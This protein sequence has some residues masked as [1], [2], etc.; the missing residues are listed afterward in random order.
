MRGCGKTQEQTFLPVMMM[1]RY[2]CDTR[3][4]LLLVL[5]PFFNYYDCYYILL[6]PMPTRIYLLTKKSYQPICE[7]LQFS[8]TERLSS[9]TPIFL[10]FSLS[11]TLSFPPFPSDLLLLSAQ[12][13]I[14]S[15]SFLPIFSP[16]PSSL[17]R[18]VFLVLV[19]ILSIYESERRKEFLCESS[20]SSSFPNTF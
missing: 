14:F 16:L 10:L 3:G 7:A 5:L 19:H 13:P 20:K 6:L 1:I 2:Y 18:N 4:L 17:F 11:F 12:Y 9:S 8:L 15:F